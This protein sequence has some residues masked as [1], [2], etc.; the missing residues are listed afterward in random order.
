MPSLP[1]LVARPSYS[2]VLVD[3]IQKRCSFLIWALGQ[4][5]MAD[6]VDV[7]CGRA[8]EIGHSERARAGFDAV[9]ARSFGPPA[10][11]VECGAPLLKPGGLLVISEPPEGRPWPAEPLAA[12]GLT[13]EP[14]L[15]PGVVVLRRSGEVA[16]HYPRRAKVQQ[17]DPLF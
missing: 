4:L 8:E 1:I 3:A 14:D 12:I 5:G 9:V 6:R 7:W 16:D 2:A 17:R 13:R 11:T 10:M 15:T